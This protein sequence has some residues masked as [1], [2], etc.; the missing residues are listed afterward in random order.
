MHPGPSCSD[1][2]NPSEG[3]GNE[4]GHSLSEDCAEAMETL[5]LSDY[6]LHRF[7]ATEAKRA[8]RRARQHGKSDRGRQEV[9]GT[10]PRLEHHRTDVA[11]S[12]ACLEAWLDATFE[13]ELTAAGYV[14]ETVPRPASGP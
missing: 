13:R 11:Y 5:A 9:K 1:F 14:R 12:I 2:P 6:W 8:A 10:A 3:D 7:A 4:L